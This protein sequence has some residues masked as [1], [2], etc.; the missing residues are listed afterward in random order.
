MNRSMPAVHGWLFA[1]LLLVGGSSGC[2]APE[3]HVHGVDQTVDQRL[4]SLEQ[5]LTALERGPHPAMGARGNSLPLANGAPSGVKP[6]LYSSSASKTRQK[7]GLRLKDPGQL[8]AS[9]PAE[10]GTDGAVE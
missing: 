4:Q 3:T 2:L 6:A 8:R 5:R 1:L 7:K 10:T 9:D